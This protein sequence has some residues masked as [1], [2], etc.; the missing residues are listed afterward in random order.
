MPSAI[1][2][3]FLDMPDRRV[4]VSVS[5]NSVF[6][7]PFCVYVPFTLIRHPIFAQSFVIATMFVRSNLR[8]NFARVY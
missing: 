4:S 3:P 7:F 5:F 1:A 6:E 8:T 2:V